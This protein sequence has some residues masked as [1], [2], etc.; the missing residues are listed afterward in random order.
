[1]QVD[2][3]RINILLISNV[4]LAKYLYREQPKVGLA[5]CYAWARSLKEAH[6]LGVIRGQA[7]KP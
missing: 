5:V 3:S 1:M 6:R 4:E 7:L 2:L